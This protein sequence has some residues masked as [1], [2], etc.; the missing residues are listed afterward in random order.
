MLTAFACSLFLDLPFTQRELLLS[1]L[2]FIGII[3]IAH[4]TS[5]FGESSSTKADSLG[6]VTQSVTIRRSN[7][8][9]AVTPTQRFVAIIVATL[10]IIGASGAYTTVR[11]IGKQAHALHMVTY[12]A[13]LSTFGSA[14]FLIFIPGISFTTPHGTEWYLLFLLGVLGFVLQFLMT[15]GLQLDSSSKATSM[16]YS[17]IVYAMIFD[18]FIWNVLPDLWSLIGGA[19]VVGSTLW[20][21]LSNSKVQCHKANARKTADEERPLLEN[22]DHQ[23]LAYILNQSENKQVRGFC[24]FSIA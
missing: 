7:L 6:L 21:A 24:N 1:I 13:L 3:I 22:S 20:S 2:A 4:P 17:Q 9:E 12:Y 16:M 10:G 23:K 19:I 8:V 14:F 5:V 15:K 18:W 11:I